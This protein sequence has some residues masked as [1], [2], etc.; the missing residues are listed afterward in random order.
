[1]MTLAHNTEDQFDEGNPF[2]FLET[3]DAAPVVRRSVSWLQKD[4]RKAKPEGP[5]YY[6]PA[7]RGPYLY[8]RL[9]I[10]TWLKRQKSN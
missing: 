5:P 7:G 2:E 9:D 1:M 3:K 6:R 8:R 10:W 4:R